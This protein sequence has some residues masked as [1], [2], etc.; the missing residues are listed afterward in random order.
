MKKTEKQQTKE[1]PAAKP[2]QVKAVEAIHGHHQGH[3]SEMDEQFRQWLAEGAT[4]LKRDCKTYDAL[5][6][7]AAQWRACAL[8]ARQMAQ[9]LEIRME[10]TD[11]VL[12][13]LAEHFGTDVLSSIVRASSKINLDEY[14][15]AQQ[16]TQTTVAAVLF[17]SFS[18]TAMNAVTTGARNSANARHSKPGG[19]R[20][21]QQKIREIW[22]SG[23]Y[24]AKDICAEQESAGLGMSF[25][26]ARKALRNA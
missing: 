16:E 1:A 2:A 15:A 22:A 26:A 8:L 21:K 20:E 3:S 12:S 13:V 9:A 18:M 19:A 11:L 7:T 17:D 10:E 25:S 14:V 6:S 4:E 23:K 5:L 24:T